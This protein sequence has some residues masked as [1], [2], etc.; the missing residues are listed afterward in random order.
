MA[1][2]SV[3]RLGKKSKGDESKSQMVEGI[4]RLICTSKSQSNPLTGELRAT[5]VMGDANLGA[6]KV[7]IGSSN[8]IKLLPAKLLWRNWNEFAFSCTFSS[9]K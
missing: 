4:S 7:C 9:P 5:T 8:E 3:M 2:F 6:V 1:V